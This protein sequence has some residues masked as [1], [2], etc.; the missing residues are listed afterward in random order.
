M[1]LLAIRSLD[2]G[3]P[4]PSLGRK[5]EAPTALPPQAKPGEGA[6]GV[7][8]KPDGTL[9]TRIAGNEAANTPVVRPTKVDWKKIQD[10]LESIAA[11]P[12]DVIKKP[13]SQAVPFYNSALAKTDYSQLEARVNSVAQAY[14]AE[15]TRPFGLE[16]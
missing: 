14:Y 11:D 7:W 3:D 13:S 4:P 16:P 12:G 1:R 10:Y 8:Q 2:A 15:L 6:P 5:V 9:E